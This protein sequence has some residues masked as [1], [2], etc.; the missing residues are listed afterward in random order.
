MPQV[1]QPLDPS[2]FH[3]RICRSRFSF[4]VAKGLIECSRPGDANVSKFPSVDDHDDGDLTLLI[5]VAHISCHL[6]ELVA[7]AR[8]CVRCVFLI[9]YIGM[10]FPC[11]ISLLH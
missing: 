5:L 6:A 4:R 7:G 10:V 2:E 1:V 11:L 9:Q 8:T 3:P